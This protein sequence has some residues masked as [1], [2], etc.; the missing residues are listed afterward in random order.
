MNQL[1]ERIEQSRKMANDDP[2][3]ELGHFRLGQLLIEAGQYEEA[4]QSLRRTLELSPQ[5]SKAYQL[6]GTALKEAGKR[7]EAVEVLKKGYEIADER[8]DHMPRDAMANLLVELGEPKPQPKR[9]ADDVAAGDGFRC[10]CPRCFAGKNAR[11]LPKPPLPDEM[12]KRIQENI[13]ASCWNLWLGDVS[14][15]VINEYRLDLSTER[16]QQM[17][18]QAM[19]EFFGLQ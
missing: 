12:G 18:D 19:L 13:C 2:D 8:G 10:K 9:S 7:D 4:I 6:L 14:V 3:N 17:Y 1:Q 5:F 16:G 15:K 11:R